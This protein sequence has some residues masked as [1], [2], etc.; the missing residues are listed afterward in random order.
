MLLELLA[1]E[2]SATFLACAHIECMIVLCA[3][4]DF[5][6]DIRGV[7]ELDALRDHHIL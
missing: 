7:R 1:K 6:G 2:T 5:V 3:S 4:M